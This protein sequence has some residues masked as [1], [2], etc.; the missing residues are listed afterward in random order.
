MSDQFS[1]LIVEPFLLEQGRIAKVFS[2]VDVI[3]RFGFYRTVRNRILVIICN[4]SMIRIGTSSWA[5]PEFVRDWY[6]PKLPAAARLSWYAEHFD[7]VE[8]NS[9]FYAIP[10]QRVTRRWDSETP[11]DFLFDVKLHGL[12]SRHAVKAVSLPP[13]I[14][15][16]AETNPNLI[17]TPKLEQLVAERIL[18]EVE[19]LR[20]ADKLGAF[21]LQLSPSFSPSKHKLDELDQLTA[22]FRD[23]R[24]AIELRNRHWLAGP[25]RDETLEFFQ[26][27]HLPFVLVDAPES[28]HFTVM[29]MENSVTN[30]KLAYLRLHGRNERGYIAGR[31]VAERFD[32][33]Y[34]EDEIAG[35]ATRVKDLAEQAEEVH[36]AFN[37]NHSLYAPKA[38]LN[39]RAAM[40]FA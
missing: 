16:H 37:N 15:G 23:E 3:T 14:R 29:Q 9:T 4:P 10:V 34:S 28:E 30:A 17:L 24:L 20:E 25:N 1:S 11:A 35:I 21:L 8:V 7:Y 27:R 12:L 33:D 38:A 19:P 40:G 36:V 39:L 26:N 31:S 18:T 22:L 2:H 6:P 5:D 32:Y 13:D